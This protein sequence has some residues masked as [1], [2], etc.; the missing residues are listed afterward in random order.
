[1]F[2]THESISLT[3]TRSEAELLST[4]LEYDLTIPETLGKMGES[5]T[6]IRRFM[7]E[8]QRNLTVAMERA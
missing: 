4:I 6:A 1:M 5:E 8:L 2:I 3:L 7:Q